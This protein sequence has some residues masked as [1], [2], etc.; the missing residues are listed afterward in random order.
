MEDNGGG[1]RRGGIADLQASLLHPWNSARAAN[2][3]I[4]KATSSSASPCLFFFFFFFFFFLLAPRRKP[5]T[6][7]PFISR[8]SAPILFVDGVGESLPIT[9][10]L[11]MLKISQTL[12]CRQLQQISPRSI[13][14]NLYG[15]IVT[16]LS[17]AC[18]KISIVRERKNVP[19]QTS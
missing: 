12:S 3:I 6:Y 5:D 7:R 19:A 16:S 4:E 15:S 18:R 8:V 17:A 2:C 9:C 10:D 13:E 11:K 14:R 1:G